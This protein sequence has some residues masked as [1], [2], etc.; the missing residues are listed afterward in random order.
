LFSLKFDSLNPNATKY[1]N[2]ETLLGIAFCIFTTPKRLIFEDVI[3]FINSQVPFADL[4]L[5]LP[6][7][8]FGSCSVISNWNLTLSAEGS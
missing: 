8:E 3:S 2:P 4:F 5:Y 6:L 1:P 7:Y